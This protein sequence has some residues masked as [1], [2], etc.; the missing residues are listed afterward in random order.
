MSES[1]PIPTPD[2]KQYGDIQERAEQAMLTTIYQALEH[3]SKQAADELKSVGSQERP[4]AYEYF[5]AVAHQKLFLLLCGADP[6]TFIG[7]NPD[8]AASII[9]N[10]QK[11]SDH[12]WT[13]RDGGQNTGQSSK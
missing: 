10:N 1:C 9:D 12:Y 4:P 3:A 13:N 6:E 11:I 2:Q 5:A 7:G 8:I